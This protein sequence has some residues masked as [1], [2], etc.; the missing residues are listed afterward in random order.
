M[1]NLKRY[2]I[3]GAIFV[4]IAGTLSH[5]VYEWSGNNFILGFFF[6]INESTWEHMKLC[7]FPM[8][9]YSFCMNKKL[10]QDY[11]CVTSALLGGT[12]LGTILIP[13][14]FYT[15]SG[16]L[17]RNILPLDIACF[18]LSVIIAFRTV[19]KLT[20]SCKMAPYTPSLK[21]L[22]LFL[23]ICFLWFTYHPLELGIFMVP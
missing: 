9:F 15:Y 23:G 1:K 19:Y 17:G 5:F 13:V 11:P 20:V 14:F 12:L 3:K 18:I 21:L 8:L 2:T 7:F 4:L 10:K 16:I 22:V 6:P